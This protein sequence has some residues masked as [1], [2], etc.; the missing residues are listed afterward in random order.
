MSEAVFLASK[1]RQQQEDDFEDELDD[2]V[3]IDD[4]FED[5]DD[6][7]K[8]R[9][10]ERLSIR[11]KINSEDIKEMVS[12]VP[13]AILT[14]EWLL[15]QAAKAVHKVDTPKPLIVQYASVY[16][17]VWSSYGT[18]ALALQIYNPIVPAGFFMVGGFATTT[19]AEGDMG[20]VRCLI[21]K[22]D[23]KWRSNNQFLPPPL[24]PPLRYE[25]VWDNG[26][27][28]R[29]PMAIWRPI[30]P[31]GYVC[32]GYVFRSSLSGFRSASDF[33]CVHKSLVQDN[34]DCS[35]HWTDRGAGSRTDCSLWEVR[36][37]RNPDVID[38][39]C[40]LAQGTYDKP[41]AGSVPVLNSKDCTFVVRAADDPSYFV[42]EAISSLMLENNSFLREIRQSKDSI[43][44]LILL[45]SHSSKKVRFQ[46]ARALQKCLQQGH[47]REEEEEE[48]HDSISIFS[49]LQKQYISIFNGR[50]AQQA[51]E[52]ASCI[53]EKRVASDN[54]ISLRQD[55]MVILRNRF[56]NDPLAI[57]TQ[58]Y[59]G[60]DGRWYCYKVEVEMDNT[61]TATGGACTLADIKHGTHVVLQNVRGLDMMTV[62]EKNRVAK[63]EE[64]TAAK[65]EKRKSVSFFAGDETKEEEEEA[66]KSEA[67][68]EVRATYLSMDKKGEVEPS[69]ALDIG[70]VFECEVLQDSSKPGSM[71]VLALKAYTHSK[72]L[73]IDR[74][75]KASSQECCGKDGQIELHP[76]ESEMVDGEERP[77]VLLCAPRYLI[78]D[79]NGTVRCQRYIAKDGR[80]NEES[81]G[82]GTYLQNARRKMEGEAWDGGSEN[83]YL[84]MTPPSIGQLRVEAARNSRKPINGHFLLQ[85][86]GA[87][88]ALKLSIELATHQGRNLIRSKVPFAKYEVLACK[89]LCQLC[90]FSDVR[91]DLVQQEFI[92]NLLNL[93]GSPLEKREVRLEACRTIQ[94]MAVNEQ[95]QSAAFDLLVRVGSTENKGVIVS[96][97]N[98]KRH[99]EPDQELRTE[100]AKTLAALSKR[101]EHRLVPNTQ[102]I[103]KNITEGR[104]TLFKKRKVAP[105]VEDSGDFS[106]SMWVKCDQEKRDTKC[107][108]FFKGA[109]KLLNMTPSVFVD[110]LN[111]VVVHISTK[112]DWT[113]SVRSSR[114]LKPRVWCQVV[115]VR[116]VNATTL[117]LDGENDTE[118]VSSSIAL[119]NTEGVRL[120]CVYPPTKEDEFARGRDDDNSSIGSGMS[121][122]SSNS[123]PSSASGSYT[124]AGTGSSAMASTMDVAQNLETARIMAEM[125]EQSLTLILGEGQT[126]TMDVIR[127]GSSNGA[128]AAAEDATPLRNSLGRRPLVMADPPDFN[129]S[130]DVTNADDLQGAFVVLM[131]SS[132]EQAVDQI[133]ALD[134]DFQASVAIVISP[135]E[136]AAS[137]A[138]GMNMPPDSVFLS[139]GVCM[140]QE[141]AKFFSTLLAPTGCFEGSICDLRFFARPI[142]SID[143]SEMYLERQPYKTQQDTAQQGV[144]AEY[145]SMVLKAVLGIVVGNPEPA[146]QFATSALGNLLKYSETAQSAVVKEI[147]EVGGLSM[148]ISNLRQQGAVKDESA[149]VVAILSSDDKVLQEVASTGL[150]PLINLCAESTVQTT[151]ES[152]LATLRNFI[153]VKSGAENHKVQLVHANA[154][155]VLRAMVYESSDARISTLAWQIMSSF[156]SSVTTYVRIAEQLVRTST[157]EVCRMVA[158]HFVMLTTPVGS[159]TILDN[160]P[161]N[162]MRGSVRHWKR[163]YPW[164]TSLKLTV[165]GF[166]EVVDQKLSSAD[167]VLSF[168]W[169]QN[170]VAC[171]KDLVWGSVE[172]QTHEHQ[173]RF[174]IPVSEVAIYYS[175]GDQERAKSTLTTFNIDVVFL[176]RVMS[177]DPATLVD[178]GGALVL[179]QL[180]K[181]RDEKTKVFANRAILNITLGLGNTEGGSGGGSSL[182][183]Q[184]ALPVLVRMLDKQQVD[185][186][187]R[188]QVVHAM[189][190]LFKTSD[191]VNAT[192]QH[193]RVLVDAMTNEADDKV[194]AR[195]AINAV[196]TLCRTPANRHKIVHSEAL[197]VLLDRFRSSKD[198]KLQEEI[199]QAI[200]WIC[201]SPELLLVLKNRGHLRSLANFTRPGVASEKTRL[202]VAKV[203]CRVGLLTEDANGGIRDLVEFGVVVDVLECLKVGRFVYCVCWLV[204]EC[205]RALFV[206]LREAHTFLLNDI[207]R[208]TWKS[209]LI[210]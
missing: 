31:E 114:P 34:K 64:D 122:G 41:K 130:S 117:Y 126:V 131:P 87:D 144:D 16:R 163:V 47:V 76:G 110:E 58:R 158:N 51:V 44:H 75:T 187:T 166:V 93:L 50:V 21:V 73:V 112:E 30:P 57:N 17:R 111:H 27:I 142:S 36:T 40:A 55:Q 46:V 141:Q 103:D 118:F 177:F 134:R 148:L 190:L 170:G 6:D 90:R 15:G 32:L 189:S 89:A 208:S 54:T 175:T 74:F 19:S 174:E 91:Q 183:S 42:T 53:F 197:D 92:Q 113:Q 172:D 80:F 12:N 193:L 119:T 107:P 153:N 99:E 115:V 66:D 26:L 121:G 70:C 85:A 37:S 94:Y 129:S 45:L 88:L 204:L 11:P 22:E 77:T 128:D 49:S 135:L 201:L 69:V 71:K 95:F 10:W 195:H 194:L 83:K 104:E 155:P 7:E 100:T 169:V 127:L 149:R 35:S 206:Y 145:D 165:D 102:A 202:F 125:G 61:V 72:F 123:A 160:F 152:V 207:H 181:K 60:K 120:G 84:V 33:R 108:V 39:R 86:A 185:L 25:F 140:P 81:V 138:D 24:A 20:D 9:L 2:L 154:V 186:V 52:N 56:W 136:S 5:D 106:V 176:Q 168:R 196:A 164:A 23:P 65:K 8:E 105:L 146:Q 161:H 98:S 63:D 13:G 14:C 3:A 173:T 162:F 139:C 29:T 179:S 156:W 147:N 199:A 210:S 82:T 79:R 192:N 159:H 38:C 184:G 78:I 180:A 96:L 209:E 151:Q 157:V 200:Q 188:T 167:E 67:L 28:S 203:F 1:V 62:E 48:M 97:F 68:H 137:C 109:L 133:G 116:N 205:V 191:S 182:L 178:S 59:P 132:A 143:V 101:T 4:E 43:Q 124:S 18:K 150:K 198:S 171:R